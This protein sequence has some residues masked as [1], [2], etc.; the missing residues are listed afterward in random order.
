MFLFIKQIELQ[1][2]WI[3]TLSAEKYLADSGHTQD[4]Q[5]LRLVGFTEVAIPTT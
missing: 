3:A 1:G 4:G 2:K 5:F